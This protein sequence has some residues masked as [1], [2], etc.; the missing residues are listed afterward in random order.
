M[1]EQERGEY[2]EMNSMKRN[3]VRGY[4]NIRNKIVQGSA[5]ER[6]KERGQERANERKRDPERVKE[7]KRGHGRAK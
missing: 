6:K 7:S 1:R 2:R 3:K 5:R 4:E